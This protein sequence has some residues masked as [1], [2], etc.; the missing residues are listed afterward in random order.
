[1]TEPRHAVPTRT[2]TRPRILDLALYL[3]AALVIGGIGYSL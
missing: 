2:R 3:V 1:M